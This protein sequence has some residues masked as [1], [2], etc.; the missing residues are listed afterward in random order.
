MPLP[1]VEAKAGFDRN[2]SSPIVARGKVFVTMSYWPGGVNAKQFPEHHVAC[3]RMSDGKLLWDTK[4]PNGPW[5]LS[6]LRGGYTAPTPAADGERVYVMFGS[7]VI[8]AL[9]YDGKIVWR[10]EIKPFAFDVCA[11]SSPV[12]YEDTVILQ[13]DQ[14]GGTSRLLAFDRKTG[15]VKWEQKRPQNGFSHST[16]TLV[17]IKDKPQLLMAASNALQGVDPDTGKVLWWCDAKGDTVSPVYRGGLVYLDS[18]RGGRAVAVDP[19]GEGNVTKTHLKWSVAQVPQGFSSP[20]IVGEYLYRLH[21]PGT[22]HCWDLNSGKAIY[23]ERLEGASAAC[24]P[25]ATPDGR[26]YCASA[27]KSV[28]VQAGPKFEVLATNEIGDGCEASPAVSDGRIYLE[29]TA[30][31]FGASARSNAGTTLPEDCPA[32]RQPDRLLGV[33]HANE[34]SANAESRTGHIRAA[35]TNAADWQPITTELLAKEKPGYGG[36]SGVVVDHANGHLYVCLSDRGVYRSTDQGKTWERFGKEAFKGR[37]EWPGCFQLDPDRQDETLPDRSGVRSTDHG[38]RWRRLENDGEG[39]R[40]SH[41]DYAVRSIGTM[42]GDEIRADGEARI[43]RQVDCVSDDAGQTFREVGKGYGP[44]WI[45]DN[46]TAVIAEIKTKDQPGGKLLRTTDGGKTFQ[47]VSQAQRS[48]RSQNG[49]TA[50][51][52]G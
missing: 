17:R 34:V 4:V 49:T 6:D 22:L 47:S 3:Y 25:I 38:R 39:V 24:S 5:L 52:T 15:E 37:T 2:Q 29:R 42:P 9:D 51:C 14:V 16:P 18:G 12:L 40:S 50:A 46:K 48:K 45:F 20:V 11:G 31:F 13:C 33:H 35:I 27:G 23:S 26:I 21:N 28:V 1:G 10:K 30:A 36:L 41:V 32:L 19:T 44:A 8:A 43:G 7:S